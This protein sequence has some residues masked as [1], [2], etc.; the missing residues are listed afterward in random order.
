LIKANTYFIFVILLTYISESNV[1]YHTSLSLT[2]VLL[3]G[4]FWGEPFINI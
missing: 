1:P 4:L 2:L 3:V